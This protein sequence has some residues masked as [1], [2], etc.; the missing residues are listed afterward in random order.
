[1]GEEREWISRNREKSLQNIYQYGYYIDVIDIL[2][3]RFVRPQLLHYNNT[4]LVQQ[5]SLL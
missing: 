3:L 4:K 1:M 2:N 5:G